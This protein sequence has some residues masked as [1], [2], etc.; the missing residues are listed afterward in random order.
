MKKGSCSY[1]SG[2]GMCFI[3]DS[4]PEDEDE[5]SFLLEWQNTPLELAKVLRDVADFLE[6]NANEHI[7][8]DI[9]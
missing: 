8:V 1:S 9:D 3:V 4:N 7:N 5:G 6:K 2:N